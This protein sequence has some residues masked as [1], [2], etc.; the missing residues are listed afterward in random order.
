[1]RSREWQ[2]FFFTGYGEGEAMHRQDIHHHPFLLFSL[3]HGSAARSR[4]H[5]VSG[6]PHYG[7]QPCHSLDF[8]PS[9][10]I[11]FLVSLSLKGIQ[12]MG[13]NPARHRIDFHH[14]F[15][16]FFFFLVPR[17]EDAYSFICLCICYR[18]L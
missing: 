7:P 3:F 16:F 8:H 12:I 11:F 10:S 13:S 4:I 17:V 2:Y 15:N 18:K 5:R 1:M 9:V 14:S 6:E